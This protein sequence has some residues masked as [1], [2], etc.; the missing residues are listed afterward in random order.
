MRKSSILT[1]RINTDLTLQV[2]KSF[3]DAVAHSLQQT[4]HRGGGG[5]DEVI[6][7]DAKLGDGA[8]KLAGEAVKQVVCDLDSIAVEDIGDSDGSVNVDEA[9]T[10][11]CV[12]E[13]IVE[14]PDFVAVGD[15]LHID[16]CSDVNAV[17][18]L[19]EGALVVVA[20]RDVGSGDYNA[21]SYP[22]TYFWRENIPGALMLEALAETVART[23][24]RTV[25]AEKCIVDVKLKTG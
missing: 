9:V 15:I 25:S 24:A 20:V 19:A 18:R 3:I 8:P 2:G 7:G 11:Q 23:Q 13:D 12:V 6:N 10:L 21:F 5:V 17:T 16:R 22:C 14:D 4:A 1:W